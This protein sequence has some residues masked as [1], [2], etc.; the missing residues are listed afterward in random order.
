MTEN[1][2]YSSTTNNATSVQLDERMSD[3]T[4][5]FV[6]NFFKIMRPSDTTKIDVNIT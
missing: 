5:Q 4:K 2:A 1:S 3:E 6:T